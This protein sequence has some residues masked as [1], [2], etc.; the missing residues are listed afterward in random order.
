MYLEMSYFLLQFK[1]QFFSFH[2][3]KCVNNCLLA[4]QFPRQYQLY[5]LIEDPFLVCDK[6]LLLFSGLPLVFENLSMMC[7]CF[8]YLFKYLFCP[9]SLSPSEPSIIPMS[10]SLM[11]PHMTLSLCSFF[12]ILFLYFCYSNLIVSIDPLSGSLILSSPYSILQL[13]PSIEFF[14]LVFVVFNARISVWFHFI[15]LISALIFFIW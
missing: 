14:I 2:N 9:L 3:F 11:V 15:I 10:I 7:L 4:S 6:M 12:L 8:Y 5:S 13:S 1:R